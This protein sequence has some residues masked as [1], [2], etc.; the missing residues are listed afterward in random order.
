MARGSPLRCLP[1]TLPPLLTDI[2][3]SGSKS[4]LV[5]SFLKAFDSGDQ[6]DMMRL[7]DTFI[8]ATVLSDDPAARRLEF[9]VRVHFAVF[10]Y[11]ALQSPKRQE[12]ITLAA[13]RRQ[14]PCLLPPAVHWLG[15]SLLPACRPP[16]CAGL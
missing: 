10:P 16:V 14:A 12:D 7:W 11:R 8:P 13:K 4:Q 1:P 2:S 5:T 15:R 3:D 9:S 6:D